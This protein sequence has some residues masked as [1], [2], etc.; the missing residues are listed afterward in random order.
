MNI[1][2]LITSIFLG[3]GLAADASAVS[4]ANGMNEPKMKIP[5]VLFISLLFGAF[6]G[7][8]PLIGY[9]VGHAVLEYI[10]KFIPWIAL[11]LL[12]F[13]GGKML[14]EG[15]N[16]NDND[17]VELKKLTIV[18][19]FVQAIATSIDALSVGFTIANYNTTEALVTTSIV[20]FVTMCFCILANYLGKKFGTKLGHKAEIIGGIILIVIGINIFVQA[21]WL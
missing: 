3:L 1:T 18:T 8:M 13:I 19:I 20:A 11:L 21:M 5:K 7:L 10:D 6:Q 17:E 2:F 12:G 16:S 4:M 15:V 9:L 14:I